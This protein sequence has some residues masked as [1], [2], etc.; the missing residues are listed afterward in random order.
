VTETAKGGSK[1][2]V[3]KGQRDKWLDKFLELRSYQVECKP[4]PANQTE[5]GKEERKE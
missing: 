5:E 2:R 1:R 4:N 3:K